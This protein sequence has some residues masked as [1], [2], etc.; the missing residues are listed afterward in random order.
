MPKNSQFSVLFVHFD[1][2]NSFSCPPN[3][4]FRHFDHFEEFLTQIDEC[5]VQAEGAG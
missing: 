3:S 2:K 4:I 5:R 1:P